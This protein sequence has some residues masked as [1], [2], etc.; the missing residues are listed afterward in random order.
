MS[1]RSCWR[2]ASPCASTADWWRL[3]SLPQLPP[4]PYARQAVSAGWCGP[5]T[6]TWARSC[7]RWKAEQRHGWG[8][9]VRQPQTQSPEQVPKQPREEPREWSPVQLPEQN[10]VQPLWQP[11]L[12]PPLQRLVQPHVLRPI[13]QQRG[14][15]G[16]IL[17]SFSG[18][19]LHF[20]INYLPSARTHPC[21]WPC[22]SSLIHHNFTSVHRLS[23]MRNLVSF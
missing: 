2:R 14:G 12:R 9:R 15:G 3:G 1:G 18:P 16:L 19:L 4:R 10:L 22:I 5:C 21:I 13:R 6:Q 23:C 8:G 17:R 11:P 20:L 7:R